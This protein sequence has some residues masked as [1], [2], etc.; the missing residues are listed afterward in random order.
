[1][2]REATLPWLCLSLVPGLGPRRSRRLLDRCGSA[3]AAWEAL[4]RGEPWLAELLPA[5]LRRKLAPAEVEH[6][7]E[8][9]LRQCEENGWRVVCFSQPQYPGLLAQ[10]PDPPLVLYVW[11]TLE[12]ADC[13]SVAIVGTRHATSYG[14][15]HARQLA[16]GLA[17]AGMSIVSGLARG[18]DAAAHRG[19]LEAGGRTLAVVAGGLDAVA[20]RENLELA[21]QIA[22]QGAVLSEQPPGVAPR[23]ELFPIRNR[24]IS[25]LSLGVLVVEAD[26]RSG[27]LITVTHALEQGREVFALPGPVQ[28]RTSRGPHQL[29][30]EGAHLVERPQDVLAELTTSPLLCAVSTP[31]EKHA[32]EET[33]SAAEPHGAKEIPAAEELPRSEA[34]AEKDSPPGASSPAGTP[35]R[36]TGA[37]AAETQGTEAHLLDVLIRQG[38][39]CAVDEL[40]A[41]SGRPTAEVL[42]ALNLLELQ[43]R[44]QRVSGQL[45]QLAADYL[46]SSASRSSK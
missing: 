46:S 17:Q 44:V 26:V 20:P 36:A 19:A 31:A 4:C 34:P 3:T 33:L 15:L 30:R 43:G 45:V 10:I 8:Q 38:G 9:V 27:A 37:S 14:K 13:W 24:I 25:G 18:V 2:E 29:L 16:A 11:G 1:M 7:A 28:N 32:A 39:S 12:A 22:A 5:S 42:A 35:P 40:V 6:R 41:A 23:G 21:R